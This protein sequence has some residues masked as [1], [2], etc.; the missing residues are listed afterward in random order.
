MIQTSPPSPEEDTRLSWKRLR[1]LGGKL[2]YLGLLK[3]RRKTQFLINKQVSFA[4][5]KT[6]TRPYGID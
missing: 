1:T 5:S 2:G 4:D 3:M 6:T